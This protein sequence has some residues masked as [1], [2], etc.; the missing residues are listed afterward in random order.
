MG[1]T[2]LGL[3]AADHAVAGYDAS[4]WLWSSTRGELARVNGLTGRVDTRVEVAESRSHRT[5]VVQT[6]Q[7]LVLRD[8]ATG[9]ISSLNLATLQIG[10]TTRSTTGLGVSVAMHDDAA[11]VIDAVQGVV[12]QLDPRSL[13]PVGEAIHYPPGITGGAFDGDGR[14]WIGVPSEGTVSAITAAPL[15]ETPD[16][17]ATISG[18]DPAGPTAAGPTAAGPTAAGPTAAGPTAAGPD[19]SG[20]GPALIRT[21]AVAP[22]SNE[23]TISALDDGVAVLNRTAGVLTVLRGDERRQV[24]LDLRGPGIMPSRSVGAQVAVTDPDAR[25]VLLV[26]DDEIR[27]FAVPGSGT[28]LRA[29][30]SWA[31]RIYCADE[32]AGQIH[33]FTESGEPLPAIAFS[34]PSGPLDLEVRENHLFINAPDSATARV[35]TDDHEVREVDK[36]ANDIL[37]GDPPPVPPPPPPPVEPTVGPPGAPR[38]VTAAAGDA[39]ARV[40][41]RAA[42][43]NG[44]SII[45]YVV[46]G[47]G[48]V[49]DVGANQRSFDVTGLTNGETYRFSVYAVN[50]EGAGPARRSNPVTPTAEVPDAPPS[51]TAQ[52][53]PDGTVAVSWA[54]ANGRGAAIAA[55]TVTAI[56]AES[57]AAVG[58]S[59]STELVLPAGALTYGTQYAFTVVATNDRGANSEP[60]PLSETVV[61]YAAPGEPGQLQASTVADQRGAIR[62]TWSPAV[63]NG[64]PVTGYVVVVGDRRIEVSGATETTVTGLG[65]GAN[66]EVSVLAVNEAGDGPA[67]RTTARTV[68]VAQVMVTGA[69]ADATSVTLTFTVDAGGGQV[70]CS[71]LADG[72]QPVAGACDSIRVTGLYPGR[73]Y[74]FTVRA[75]NAAGTG[76]ATHS[77][78]TADLIGVATCVNGPDGAQR[79]Y[80]DDDVAGR[81]GNEIFAV[82]E[83]DNDRQVGWVPNGT[84]LTA[85]CRRAGEHVDAWIYNG[86][87]AST[88]WIRVEYEGQNY[89]PWAWLNLP[90]DDDLDVLP[91]C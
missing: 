43:A 17:S 16:T 81:N 79:T 23:L 89:I 58:D 49:F 78:S 20:A 34:H 71:A 32:R 3:G 31:G 35:V 57:A 24:P 66:V 72:G 22:P 47:A 51:V 64:R 73:P 21:V 56:S 67:A 37:G 75:T 11:F 84:R 80:C 27:E 87:K 74:N 91:S 26:S 50:A 45:R 90:G 36:Y 8:L 9:Q 33:T 28:A 6:D 62:V 40:S 19:A 39:S 83:Q 29:A 55:Y 88:W 14:L 1:L 30:V 63:E 44:A 54:A 41:W 5:H 38:D 25:R 10:A 7:F 59:T 18:D 85:L 76:S 70:T 61:P 86:H 15:P 12:R 69:T 77:R 42:S 53:R 82:P 13:R 68:A 60:S 48:Q 52:A 46:E 4:S 65:D 2:V